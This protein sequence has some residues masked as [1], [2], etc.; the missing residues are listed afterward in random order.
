MAAG[1]MV[2]IEL[3]KAK[4]AMCGD[5]SPTELAQSFA[6]FAKAKMNAAG[7]A[8]TTRNF[9]LILMKGSGSMPPGWLASRSTRTKMV[10]L[11]SAVSTFTSLKP[12]CRR[13]GATPGVPS[14]P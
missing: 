5:L 4:S 2:H 7:K 12:I 11:A 1:G 10:R 13:A 8:T 9:W 14:F 3:H 6:P